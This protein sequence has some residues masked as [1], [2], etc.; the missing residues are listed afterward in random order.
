MPVGDLPR[1]V[2]EYKIG[3]LAEEVSGQAFAN[4]IKHIVKHSPQYF[5]DRLEQT[6]KDFNMNH[7][8]AML[9]KQL[10]DNGSKNI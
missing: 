2:S 6:S 4:A 8:T 1:L 9:L 3:V 10:I 7:I 5:S